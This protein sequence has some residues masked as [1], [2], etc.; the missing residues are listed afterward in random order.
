MKL[1]GIISVDVDVT[2]EILIRYFTFDRYCGRKWKYNETE[3]QLFIGFIE[4]CDS[5]RREVLHN[6]L[7]E[8]GV[9]NAD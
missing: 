1:L 6:I 2:D 3:Y 5:V 8:F 7:I 4:A 9:T